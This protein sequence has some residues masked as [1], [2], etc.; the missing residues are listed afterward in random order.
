MQ[1]FNLLIWVDSY[2]K[3]N[4]GLMPLPAHAHKNHLD[5]FLSLLTS[6]FALILG[7]GL[8]LPLSLTQQAA[9]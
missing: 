3:Q 1:I 9:V 5:P 8:T 4:T 6:Y 2:F 7:P